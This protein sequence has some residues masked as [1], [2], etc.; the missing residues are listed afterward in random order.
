MARK[1]RKTGISKSPV[2]IETITPETKIRRVVTN[3]ETGQLEVQHVIVPAVL[4]Q[5]KALRST[6][7]R[8]K[9]NR[10]AA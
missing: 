5:G 10:G 7:N 8:G 6:T 3:P 9:Q 2:A 1:H 4:K